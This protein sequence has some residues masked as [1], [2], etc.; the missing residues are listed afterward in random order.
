ML[1]FSI[2]YYLFVEQLKVIRA[3]YKNA[4]FA[5]MDSMFLFLNL[6]S[7]PYRVCRKY[8][9]KKG[10]KKNVYGETPLTTLKKIV[11]LCGIHPSDSIIELGSGRG[12]TCFFLSNIVGSKVKGIENV[13]SFTKKANFIQKLTG[14]KNLSFSCEDFFEADFSGQSVV[15]LYAPQL[16]DEKLTTLATKLETLP[17]G[18]KVITIS[19]SMHEYSHSFEAVK[20]FS[21]SFPWGR[22]HCYLTRKK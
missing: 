7:N 16:E 8:H 3:F 15:Y 20:R 6:F 13:A 9:A 14:I 5:L 18:A 1:Y 4:S 12:R 22:T 2:K 19:Y 10:E 17:K 11:H 21:V